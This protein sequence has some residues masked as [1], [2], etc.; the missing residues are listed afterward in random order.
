MHDLN[1]NE[2]ASEC[3]AFFEGECVRIEFPT[4]NACTE[5]NCP[6]F[7]W[8]SKLIDAVAKSPA[9]LTTKEDTEYECDNCRKLVRQN[10]VLRFRE[11][12]L[13]ATC[14]AGA[15]TDRTSLGCVKE[16]I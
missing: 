10:E 8:V 14:C 3:P 5:R 4:D 9:G 11:C 16:S 7:F 1:F 12:N 6:S 13:C 2:F 15:L